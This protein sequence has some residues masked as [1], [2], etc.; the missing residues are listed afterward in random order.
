MQPSSPIK[1][2]GRRLLRP[3]ISLRGL[4]VLVALVSVAFFGVASVRQ[5]YE[6]DSAARAFLE[7]E[8]GFRFTI[9]YS[10]P[11]WVRY[12]VPE[13]V[14]TLSE[15]ANNA[16]TTRRIEVDKTNAFA[17]IVDCKHLGELSLDEFPIN[18]DVLRVVGQLHR[19]EYFGVGSC[20][21]DGSALQVLSTL[22]RLRHVDIVD[23]S[24]DS[25][26]IENVA[27]IKG[28]ETLRVSDIEEGA[29][30]L[31]TLDVS[32][33]QELTLNG[34]GLS[35]EII[36]NLANAAELHSLTLE[37][38]PLT[39]RI[40]ASLGACRKLERL[41]LIDTQV[42][43]VGI[44]ALAACPLVEL[45]MKT[46]SLDDAGAECLAKLRSLE[47]IDI[48]GAT[49]TA[50]GLAQLAKV[51]TLTELIAND[52]VLDSAAFRR[53][54]FTTTLQRLHLM[55]SGLDD[56]A[57]DAFLKVRLSLGNLYLYNSAMSVT[58]K[59]RLSS[60]MRSV[61]VGP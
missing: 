11:R 16:W 44:D 14:Q 58:G 50:A 32:R 53:I 3:R 38:A 6:K 40:F 22:P 8:L 54:E 27:K 23:C 4:L 9:E 19:L 43:G 30:A 34:R 61:D 47:K 31:Q 37:N 55:N 60:A 18:K 21:I 29:D 24:P 42:T 26:A 25:M 35:D 46:A 20:P 48:S 2:L 13:R 41:T 33:L 36:S 10:L 49:I 52:I 59:A 56:R 7:S 51:P 1:R 39:D 17:R 5:A 57:I 28:L 45:S 12:R 15:R